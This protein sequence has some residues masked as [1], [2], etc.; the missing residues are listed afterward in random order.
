M[1]WVNRCPSFERATHRLEQVGLRRARAPAAAGAAVRSARRRCGHRLRSAEQVDAH[2]PSVKSPV[3]LDDGGIQYPAG[4]GIAVLADGNWWSWTFSSPLS[5]RLRAPKSADAEQR[6]VAAVAVGLG[7]RRVV[8][9]GDAVPGD[10]A[11]QKRVV[12]VLPAQPLVVVQLLRQVHLVAGAAELGA[13][14][15][16]A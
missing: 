6:H 5:S 2:T 13:S 14:C 11:Q 7:L 8:E 1:P 15:A 4:N 16:A 12:V 9:A 3:C 10:A